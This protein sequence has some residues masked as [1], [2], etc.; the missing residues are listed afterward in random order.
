MFSLIFGKLTTSFTQFATYQG[1]LQSQ[2]A[3]P[4]PAVV[5]AFDANRRELKHDAG[6]NASY[7]CYIGKS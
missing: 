3:N 5:A 1:I 4:D 6:N 2:G 7:L